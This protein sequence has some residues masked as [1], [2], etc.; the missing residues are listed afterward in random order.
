MNNKRRML[1]SIL[2]ILLGIGLI[3]GAL[4]AK[5]DS[6]WSGLGTA[7]LF[8]GALQMVRWIRYARNPEYREKVEVEN[9]D[10]RNRSLSAKAWAWAGYLF[11]LL[12]AVASILLR[13]LKQELLSM[14]AGG[15]VCLIIT[16]YW[17]TYLILKKKY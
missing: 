16:L 2:W 11:V 12:C 15:A 13:V 8:V 9:K 14:A 3:V 4:V 6:F 1:V 5:M 17:I 7:F 10:E